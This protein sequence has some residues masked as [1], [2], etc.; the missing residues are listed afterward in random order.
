M[1][2]DKT[3]EKFGQFYTTAF[4]SFIVGTSFD[5]RILYASYALVKMYAF[6]I[7]FTAMFILNSFDTEFTPSG[8]LAFNKLHPVSYSTCFVL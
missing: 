5:H 7:I 1:I 3:T 8:R 6:E 4:V 2:Y